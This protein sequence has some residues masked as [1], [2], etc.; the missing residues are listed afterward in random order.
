MRKIL[1]YI[2]I[3]LSI[4]SCALFRKTPK[5]IEKT[6]FYMQTLIENVI[7][8]SQV[9]SICISDKILSPPDG[10][11]KTVFIDGETG[12]PFEEYL[13]ILEK[14]DTT[15]FYNLIPYENNVYFHKRIQIE[16]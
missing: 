9:D 15:Y 5:E 14:G 8:Y 7:T 12:E 4:S 10:W 16:N 3:F 1:L 13:Y 11:T 2:I 6:N